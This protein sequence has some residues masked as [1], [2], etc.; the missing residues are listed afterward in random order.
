M[1]F[2][3]KTMMGAQPA[4]LLR[5]TTLVEEAEGRLPVHTLTFANPPGVGSL[6]VRMDVG[7]VV[8][9]VVP[10]YKPK[11]YSMSDERPGEFDI[12]VKVYPNGRA[13]GCVP[14]AY[15]KQPEECPL[16]LAKNGMIR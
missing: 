2:M 4:T 16:D 5:K 9:V 3:I 1:E 11:S 13:S 12:T 8:K 15:T 14:Y 10:G 7:D 6:G